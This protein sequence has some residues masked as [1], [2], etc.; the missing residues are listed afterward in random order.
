VL[1]VVRQE[2]RERCRVRE[3]DRELTYENI[4]DNMESQILDSI[5]GKFLQVCVL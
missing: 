3:R 1:E 5:R 2:E 4:L